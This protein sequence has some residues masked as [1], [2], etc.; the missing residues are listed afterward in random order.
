MKVCFVIQKLAGLSGGAE[1][2]LV[3]VCNGMAARGMDVTIL[4][5]DSHAG[6][7]YYPLAGVTLRNLFPAPRVPGPAK[8][9]TRRLE[10]AI[11]AIPDVWPLPQIKWAVTYGPFINRLGRAL[12][13]IKPDVVVGFL[14]T[15]IMA[16]VQAASPLN[17]PVVASTHNVPA[18]DFGTGGRWDTNP[19]YRKARNDSLQQ[20]AR[21]LVLQ[22]GFKDGFGPALAPKTSVMANPIA[23]ASLPLTGARNTT[24]IGVG[25]LTAIKRYDILIAA[26]A[27]ISTAHPDWR[28][29][30]YGEG[31]EAAALQA[32]ID[33]LGL[34]S[35]VTLAGV[36]TDIMDIY[37]Q[38]AILCHP[39]AF[40]GF[41]LSVAEAL[42][43][44]LPVV[45]DATCSGVNAL[46]QDGV[47]GVLV[48]AGDDLTAAFAAALD[49]LIRAPDTRAAMGLAAP[50]SM[51]PY[52]PDTIF[53][54]WE[55]LLRSCQSDPDLV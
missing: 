25:R 47:T 51:H 2:I 22:E 36:S 26:W 45:A 10:R 49:T 39:A 8:G 4:T 23:Q 29:T 32:Q 27:Q 44:G 12:T 30:L 41:G 37:T 19:L 3:D 48:K 9:K 55:T 21:I 53:D 46:V 15:G 13:Q 42:A 20:A 34:A 43:H 24:V 16:A 31:P 17:I 5:Y 14:P 1:R 7:P 28:L 40:E 18:Q 52:A 54:R 35:S 6:A 50:A 11:K 33:R 38:A